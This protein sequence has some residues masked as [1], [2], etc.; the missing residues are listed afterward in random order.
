MDLNLARSLVTL[1]AFIAFIVIA[2]QAWR[3]D[4]RDGH[5]EAAALPFGDEDGAEAHE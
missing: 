2:L 1:F 5:A 4:Q 3:D